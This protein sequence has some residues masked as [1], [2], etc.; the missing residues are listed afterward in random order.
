[1][2]DARIGGDGVADAQLDHVAGDELGRRQLVD[3][4]AAAQAA[5]RLG[6]QALQG[7]E[8]ARRRRLLPRA[9]DGVEE[10]DEQDHRR[11]DPVVGLPLEQR[12]SVRERRHRQQDLDQPVVELR[13]EERPQRRARVGL[14]LVAA[15]LFQQLGRARVAQ[16][17]IR[18]HARLLEHI[19]RRRR[20][21]RHHLRAAAAW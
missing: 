15:E 1:L 6:L 3:P 21:R 12:E 19:L 17:R 5:R 10:E 20:V 18:H 14:E 2:H 7:R 9:D 8:R 4:R 11:L 13:E 16:P